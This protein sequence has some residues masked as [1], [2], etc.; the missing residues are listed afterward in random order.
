MGGTG[1]NFHSPLSE[2]NFQKTIPTPSPSFS[3]YVKY[4]RAY[5][6]YQVH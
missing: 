5:K 1:Q 4:M 2:K 6:T 3:Q